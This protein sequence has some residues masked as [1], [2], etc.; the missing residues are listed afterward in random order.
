MLFHA[1]LDKDV[2]AGWMTRSGVAGS[3]ESEASCLIAEISCW[4]PG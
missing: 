1:Y 4:E 3:P 2:F